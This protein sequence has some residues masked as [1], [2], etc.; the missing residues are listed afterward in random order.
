MNMQPVDI[1]ARLIW[2]RHKLHRKRLFMAIAGTVAC[3]VIVW[4]GD[5]K[6]ER[7]LAGVGIALFGGWSLYEIYC[8]IWP[9]DALVELLPQGII[10][11][12]GVEDFIVPW[13][14]IHGVDS[15]TVQAQWRGKTIPVPNVTVIVVSGIFYDRVIHVDS[16]FLRGPGWGNVFIPKGDK[17]QIAMHHATIPATPEE[18]RRQV[19]TRWRA[20]GK[21]ARPPAPA[22]Q[23]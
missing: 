15:I 21:K 2:G 4:L 20:F 10:F 19:E 1:N 16:L 5:E 9:G 13:T 6:I 18:I 23:P 11:R 12:E 7:F 14:E 17:V 3:I 8:L 22:A